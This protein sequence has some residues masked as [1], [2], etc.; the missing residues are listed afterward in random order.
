MAN[1]AT[2]DAM[3]AM[4]WER[5]KGELRSIYHLFYCDSDMEGEFS[6]TVE[7]FINDVEDKSIGG[8]V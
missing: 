6:A 8:F 7:E 1:S 2:R 4:A 5:A 3:K